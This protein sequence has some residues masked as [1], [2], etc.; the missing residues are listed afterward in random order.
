M[1]WWFDLKDE[2]ERR[3]ISFVCI[4]CLRTVYRTV[5][6]Y[7][8][9]PRK[10]VSSYLSVKED[11]LKM[12]LVVD[13]FFLLWRTEKCDHYT[14]LYNVGLRI[15]PHFISIKGEV[16]FSGIIISDGRNVSTHHDRFMCVK[17]VQYP[18]Y[19]CQN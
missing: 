7:S 11:P 9:G 2:R 4:R 18:S 5:N 12:A 19:K 1:Y 17:Q 10:R 8:C 13:V 16:S 15:F 6:V 3:K 14:L